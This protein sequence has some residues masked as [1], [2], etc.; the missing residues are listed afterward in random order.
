M[1][2]LLIFTREDPYIVTLRNAILKCGYVVK[3]CRTIDE[4]HESFKLSN[5]DLVFIDTRRNVSLP[6]LNSTINNQNIGGQY[7]PENICSFIRKLYQHIVIVA[8]S[9]NFEDRDVPSILPLLNQGFNKI[10]TETT[11]LNRCINELLT[12]EFGEVANV[13]RLQAAH[14]LFTALEY[15]NDSIEILNS[16]FNLLYANN[17]FEKLTG[18]SLNEVCGQ[19]FSNVHRLGSS[20]NVLL[21]NLQQGNVCESQMPFVKSNGETVYYSSYTIPVIVQGETKWAPFLVIYL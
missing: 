19:N 9:H 16:H 6:K 12:L 5:Y 17:S 21:E 14:V 18:H 20:G 7:E 2:I 11:N 13:K 8:I 10:F 15:A 1:K 3:C 4:I